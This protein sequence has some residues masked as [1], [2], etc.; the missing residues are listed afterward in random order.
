MPTNPH[1]PRGPLPKQL[2]KRS[3]P[4]P[5]I[6]LVISFS[7]FYPLPL[8]ASTPINVDI[9]KFHLASHPAWVFVN[10]IVDRFTHG[11]DIGFRA[12]LTE[13]KTEIFPGLES[14]ITLY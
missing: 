3:T 8:A 6:I 1:M 13:R 10:Y 5:L 9:L 12:T 4:T 2:S 7:S 11:F 14:G